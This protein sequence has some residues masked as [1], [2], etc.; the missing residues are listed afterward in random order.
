[1][2]QLQLKLNDKLFQKDPQS[3]DLGMRIVEKSIELIDNLGFEAF[4]FKKLSIEIES[5]EA[6]I[7]RYFE[8]KHRLLIYLISWY[9]SWTEYRITF[10]TH[11]ID[12][13]S[14]QLAKALEVICAKHSYD[15][16]FPIVDEAALQR[17]LINESD[18][19]YLTK[20]IDEI[21]KEGV[22]KGYKS[23]CKLVAEMIKKINPKFPYPYALIST[24]LEASHQQVFF[25]HHLSAL[26]E[27]EREDAFEKISLFI[28]DLVFTAINS[29]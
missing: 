7:Y 28:K 27:F 24:I 9:W 19:T 13:P 23:L 25:A 8:N 14:A 10:D 20:N 15:K 1:M 5:T 21:N 22:F 3:T 17:I 4:T 12:D 2:A 29:K 18:K 6:S 11:A 16:T 26:T